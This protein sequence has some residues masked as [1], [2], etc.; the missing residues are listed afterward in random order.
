[1]VNEKYNNQ[2]TIHDKMDKN[3]EKS[4]NGDEDNEEEDHRCGYFGW[5]P[6]CLQ[7]FNTPPWLLTCMMVLIFTLGKHK[8]SFPVIPILVF[9]II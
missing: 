4:V 1:M 7:C 3:N 8:Y 5:T 9:R 2:D 6:D